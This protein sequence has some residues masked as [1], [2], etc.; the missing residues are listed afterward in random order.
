MTSKY[1]MSAGGVALPPL[2]P[3]KAAA[4]LRKARK[5]HSAA[6]SIDTALALQ[7]AQRVHQDAVRA[8]LTIHERTTTCTPSGSAS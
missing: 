4:R 5:A 3:E 8:A 1:R 6:P 2:S 7:A